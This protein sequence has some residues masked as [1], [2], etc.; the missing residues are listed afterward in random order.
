LRRPFC[1]SAALTA[2]A[3]PDG[4]LFGILWP[5]RAGA[6]LGLGNNMLVRRADDESIGGY[7]TLAPPHR[8]EGAPLPV[9]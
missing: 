6:G 8:V 4:F 5:V 2:H 7:E 9:G 1:L 3:A